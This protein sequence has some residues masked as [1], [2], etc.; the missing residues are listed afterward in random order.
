MFDQQVRLEAAATS[1][2]RGAA[3]RGPHLNGWQCQRNSCKMFP[4]GEGNAAGN[5]LR[6]PVNGGIRCDV[7]GIVLDACDGNDIRVKTKVSHL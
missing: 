4:V 7:L 6:L 1:L 2:S 3:R 5:A